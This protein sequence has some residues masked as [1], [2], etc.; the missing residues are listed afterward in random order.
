MTSHLSCYYPISPILWRSMYTS[1]CLWKMTY[2]FHIN[3]QF[4][5]FLL[6][7]DH[8]TML[9]SLHR[10]P[11]GCLHIEFYKLVWNIPSNNSSV[12]HHHH[13]FSLYQRAYVTLLQ[14]FVSMM[15]LPP[16]TVML[17][18]VC[19]LPSALRPS[20]RHPDICLLMHSLDISLWISCPVWCQ[21][22][23]HS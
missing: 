7:P 11:T 16:S 20:D 13:H 1:S 14:H 23:L 21:C 18:V 3:V 12:P 10:A 19:S 17:Q 15:S 9:V 4:H 22:C 8:L 2:C 6:V 5:R